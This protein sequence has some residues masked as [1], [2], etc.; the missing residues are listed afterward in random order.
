MVKNSV[1]L[2]GRLTRD[3]EIIHGSTGTV[4]GHGRLAINEKFKEKTITTY[5]NIKL[6]NKKAEALKDYLKKGRLICVQG[7]L[8]ANKFETKNR[9]IDTMEVIVN[10]VA[11]LDK[12]ENNTSTASIQSKEPVVVMEEVAEYEPF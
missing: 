12:K 9:K 3:L 2:I 7:A 6:F 8:R 4:I 10:E 1:T 11:L 5:I